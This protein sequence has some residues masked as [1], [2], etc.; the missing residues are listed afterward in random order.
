MAG[1]EAL[2]F[3]Y[4]RE[5]HDIKDIPNAAYLRSI[6]PQ[7]PSVTLVVAVVGI[8]PL[9]RVTARQSRQEVD[10][11]E[12][13]V[14]DETR[15]GF[16]VTFWLPVPEAREKLKNNSA[17]EFREKILSIRLRDIVLM[18]NVGLGGFQDLVYGQS[19]WR[20]MTKVELLHRQQ[21][22]S[23]DTQGTY[24]TIAVDTAG[25]EDRL[26]YKVRSVRDWLMNFVG[27]KAPGR[28]V[29]QPLPPDTQ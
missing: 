23:R 20:G 2:P 12:L 3:P 13:I 18:R 17:A 1:S 10:I 7:T 22:D 24:S 15:T 28:T 8:N 21:I 19:L 5:L 25:R 29:G 9:R 6:I 26:L 16:G 14:G 27:T 4:P 11:L